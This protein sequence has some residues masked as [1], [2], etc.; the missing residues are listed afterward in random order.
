MVTLS[1]QLLV[2]YIL[3]EMPSEGSGTRMGAGML[4]EDVPTS[5]LPFVPARGPDPGATRH[6][7]AVLGCGVG[8]DGFGRQTRR[9]VVQHCR[10]SGVC[11]PG[12]M[13]VSYAHLARTRWY[14]SGRNYLQERRPHRNR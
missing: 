5:V 6:R 11:L 10:A 9:S 13:G 8:R 12:R 2:V 14:A 7:H 4:A 1:F 3:P